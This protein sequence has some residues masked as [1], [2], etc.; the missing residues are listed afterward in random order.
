MPRQTRL[1]K[2]LWS[3]R[4]AVETALSAL[5]YHNGLRRPPVRGL[6]RMTLYVDLVRLLRPSGHKFGKG[7]GVSP[8]LDDGGGGNPKIRGLDTPHAAFLTNDLSK[9]K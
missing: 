3:G 1:W 8:F 7:D 4:N 5:K 9:E 2:R 6:D